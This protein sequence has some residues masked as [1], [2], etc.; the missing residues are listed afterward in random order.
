LNIA[1]VDD[2]ADIAELISLWLE[3]EGYSCFPFADGEAFTQAAQKTSFEVVLLDWVMPEVDGEQVLNWMRSRRGDDTPVIFI[4]A[5]TT[6]A[7]MIR[8]LNEGADDYLTKP[9]SKGE[10][11]ARISAVTRRAGRRTEQLKMEYGPYEINPRTR[12]L[13]FDGEQVR[14]TAKEFELA[15]YIFSNMGRLLSRNQILSTVWGYEPDVNTRTIDTH[16]S[17]IRKKLHLSPENG[18]RLSSI[19]HQGY[20]LEQLSPEDVVPISRTAGRSKH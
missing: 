1:V 19:Y 14:L 18:W 13:R 15:L 12:T 4:T 3:A 6:E 11:L 5:R 7:D 10:L 8:I 9:V 17:R 2:D 16:I 20:R